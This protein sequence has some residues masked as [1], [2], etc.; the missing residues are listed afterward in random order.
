M[1]LAALHKELECREDSTLHL[2]WDI[3]NIDCDMPMLFEQGAVQ[4]TT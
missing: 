4:V 3:G 1:A 2:I